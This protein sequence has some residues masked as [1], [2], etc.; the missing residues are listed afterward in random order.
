MAS[1]GCEWIRTCECKMFGCEVCMYA[2][3]EECKRVKTLFW[4]D[5]MQSVLNVYKL[6]LLGD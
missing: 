2:P 3:C 6:I 4:S 1:E 5:M